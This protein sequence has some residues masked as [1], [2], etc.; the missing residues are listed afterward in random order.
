MRKSIGA[1]GGDERSS[2]AKK[3]DIYQQL[4]PS[5]DPVR[6]LQSGGVHI[7]SHMIPKGERAA[8]TQPLIIVT[9]VDDLELHLRNAMAVRLVTLLGHRDPDGSQNETAA[10]SH[11]RHLEIQSIHAPTLNVAVRAKSE[12]FVHILRNP[13]GIASGASAAMLI[14]GAAV[15]IRG[16]VSL[17][18][19]ADT[20]DI[21]HNLLRPEQRIS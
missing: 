12:P 16:P 7:Y 1:C 11:E 4:R 20:D 18:S 3:P 6:L 10:L 14:L 15:D 19:A 21:D 17:T 2:R 5:S 13:R 8:P 9:P